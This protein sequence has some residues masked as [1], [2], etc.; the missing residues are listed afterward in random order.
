[1]A[2][3][4]K[5]VPVRTAVARPLPSA[6]A[7][8]RWN[9]DRSV[10]LRAVVI[11]LAAL[12]SFWPALRGGPVLDDAWYIFENPLMK[13]PAG[14]AKFWFA[15]GSWIE[16]YPL[17][18]T[19]LWLEYQLWGDETL[20]YH[21][22]NLALH[23]G[24]ALLVWRLLSKFGIRWAWI[25]GLIF[26]VH[27]AQVESVA[28]MTELKNTLSLAPF[29]GA[30]MAW[31]DFE[32]RGEKREYLAALGLFLVAMLCK[33]SMAPF[34]AVILLYAWWKRGRVGWLDIKRS[35]PFGLISIE[36]VYASLL[37][38]GLY[39][40]TPG[41]GEE[42][43][44]LGGFLPRIANGGLIL[45][46]Y[47]GRVILPIG[48]TPEAPRWQVDTA[49]PLPYLPWVFLTAFVGWAWTRRATWGRHALLG[50][51]FF[52]LNIAPFLGFHAVSYMNVT[53]VWDHLLY[54]PSI[55]LIGLAAAALGSDELRLPIAARRAGGGACRGRR[56]PF[57]AGE[58][59][60]RGRLP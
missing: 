8:L 9:L 59:Y 38:S 53:W 35:L 58:F 12:V 46:H 3:S 44:D 56:L 55:G 18:E 4:S 54:L 40:R 17:Q 15:P 31:I 36:L 20:G 48:L 60:L 24:N 50:I 41:N 32:E 52:L 7:A 22:V 19:V 34:P 45:A 39:E 33:I 25:G 11:G 29:L 1:M 49:S 14:L 5:T 51:G 28:N 43:V 57:H 13:D 23:V 26:A 37:V 10:L 2:R 21:L 16:F 27:P 42:A 6:G 47:V 30:M